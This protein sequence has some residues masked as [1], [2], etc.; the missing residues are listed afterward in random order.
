MHF[1]KKTKYIANTKQHYYF[2][3]EVGVLFFLF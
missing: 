1:V 3:V 2:F